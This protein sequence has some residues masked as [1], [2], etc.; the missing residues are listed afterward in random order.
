LT[1]LLEEG[2]GHALVVLRL[3]LGLVLLAH[4][5]V[6]ELLGP[7]QEDVLVRPPVLAELKLG[8]LLGLALGPVELGDAQAHPLEDLPVGLGLPRRVHEL[9]VEP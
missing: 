1:E 6:G 4:P 2:V 5:V 9:L 3:Q 8:R 7:R